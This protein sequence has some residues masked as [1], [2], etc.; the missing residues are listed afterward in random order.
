MGRVLV[1]T[2]QILKAD[3]YYYGR[4]SVWVKSWAEALSLL[5]ERHGSD[6]LVALYPTAAMQI[7]E[8]NARNN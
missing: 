4:G 6:A 2:P 1:V 7:S 5:E 8:K 3:E